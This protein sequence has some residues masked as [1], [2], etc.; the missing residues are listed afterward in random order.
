MVAKVF[1]LKKEQK[2]Y[3]HIAKELCYNKDT[4]ERIVNAKTLGDLYRAMRYG[5]ETKGRAIYDCVS[6]I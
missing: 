4:L 3:L 6:R 5:R 1:N 2:N